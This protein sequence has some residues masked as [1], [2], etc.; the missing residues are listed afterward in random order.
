MQTSQRIKESLMPQ[1][2][3]DAR[4]EMNLAEFPLCALAHR[5]NPAVKTLRFEDRVWDKGRNEWIARQLTVTGSDAFG[6]PTALDD[7]VLLPHGLLR[8]GATRPLHQRIEQPLRRRER[9]HG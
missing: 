9:R 2:I 3:S 6:L 5:L 1:K 4:D 8:P 7:V